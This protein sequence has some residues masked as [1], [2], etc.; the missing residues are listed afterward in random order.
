MPWTAKDAES[1]THLANTEYLQHLWA[2]TANNA[3]EKFKD[4]GKAIKIANAAVRKAKV[5]V[6]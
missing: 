5:R 6:L 1:Y 4:D 2:K 3:L